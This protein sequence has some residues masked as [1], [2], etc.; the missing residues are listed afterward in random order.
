MDSLTCHMSSPIRSHD[1]EGR[2]PLHQERDRVTLSDGQSDFH[3]MIP[4]SEHRGRHLER[5]MKFKEIFSGEKGQNV[6]GFFD[7]FEKFCDLHGHNDEYKVRNFVLCI[8]GQAYDSYKTMDPNIKNSYPAL[9]AEFITYFA[10]TKLPIYD[11][12]QQLTKL[13]METS[14]TVQSFF[15]KIMEKSR[16][17]HFTQEHKTFFFKAGLPKYIQKYLKIE[18]AT[19]LSETLV[20]ARVAENLGPNYD[21]DD[22]LKDIRNSL[23]ILTTKLDTISATA[24]STLNSEDTEGTP[25]QGRKYDAQNV[26]EMN[27]IYV[28]RNDQ[29][30]YRNSYPTLTSIPALQCCFC[31]AKNHSMAQCRKFNSFLEKVLNS[32][33]QLCEKI[34]HT[35]TQCHKLSVFSHGVDY[36]DQFNTKWRGNHSSIKNKSS[37]HQESQGPKNT[38]PSHGTQYNGKNSTTADCINPT[39]AVID[40]KKVHQCFK[41]P[42]IRPESHQMALS[43]VTENTQT[44]SLQTCVSKFI[45]TKEP[46][47]FFRNRNENLSYG[48]SPLQLLC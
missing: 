22:D 12:M 41:K 8:D 26:P 4:P 21:E 42:K 47:T 37:N 44:V 33:C 38:C 23:K 15:N 34:G 20:K 9:K 2:S 19:T 31:G 28:D 6:E 40:V 17:L 1:R 29:K 16:Y 24:I 7:R 36:S 39:I 35:A 46:A 30:S 10:P 43:E 18:R 45:P 32:K 14:D 3:R 48:M 25:S 11:Q 5:T 13:K 27:A